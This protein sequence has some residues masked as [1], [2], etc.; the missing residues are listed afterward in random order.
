MDNLIIVGSVSDN[1]FVDDMVQHLRQHEDYSDLISL[2]SF[3]NTE[4]CPRFI[5]DENDWD[6]IGRK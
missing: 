2:K 1:P 6:L 4:F 5:V 3:L